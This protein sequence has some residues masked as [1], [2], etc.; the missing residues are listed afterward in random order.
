MLTICPTPIG[1]LDD[2]TDR[3]REALASAD[4]IACEDTRR[5]GKLLERLGIERTDRKPRL[6][7]YHEHNE[8]EAADQLVR[9]LE[10][11]KH[12]VLVSDA[13]TPGLSDPGYEL[14]RRAAE[15]DAA[16]VSL[17]GPAAAVVALVG[18]GLPTDAFQFRGFPPSSPESRRDFLRRIDSPDLTAVLYESPSRLVAL[19]ED[20][21][22]VY[23]PARDVCVAR[24]QT[25][26]HEEWVRG[27]AE[28]VH[29]ELD[30]RDRV[31]GEC[32]VVIDR[33][34]ARDAV[35]E[36]AVDRKIRELDDRGCSHRTIREV[37]AELFGLSRS[38]LY[39]RI[40]SV[41]DE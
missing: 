33:G 9:A 4:V 16:V 25:K 24:E 12:V 15:S 34:E 28:D 30:A 31:R 23:G 18:S 32:T 2:V 36:E 26:R 37:I 5:T 39:D 17:P 29:R 22:E 1:N 19:L 20:V 6:Q 35:S 14:V 21:V 27:E 38:D 13:G 7:A 10:V 3:Q 40:E 11:G 41:L 8:R